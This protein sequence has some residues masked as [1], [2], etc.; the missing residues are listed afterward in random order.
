M[1]TWKTKLFGGDL[2]SLCTWMVAGLAIIAASLWLV[3]KA[4]LV[5]AGCS[6]E[7]LLL[8]AIYLVLMGLFG[9]ALHTYCARV[10]AKLDADDQQKDADIAA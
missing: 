6:P 10:A 2:L 7:G 9:L 3:I 5:G 1:K 8:I 4:V